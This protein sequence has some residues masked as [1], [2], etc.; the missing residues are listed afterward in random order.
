MK[1][2]NFKKNRLFILILIPL[3]IVLSLLTISILNKFPISI[4]TKGN[5]SKEININEVP[6]ISTYYIE[7][8]VEPNADVIIDFYVTD[9]YHK[10]YT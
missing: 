5:L 8:K 3:L 4:P 10:E 6:Y 2:F 1:K 7:P 9:Y